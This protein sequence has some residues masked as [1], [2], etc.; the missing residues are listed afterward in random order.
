MVQC[1][2]VRLDSTFHLTAFEIA[3]VAVAAVAVV[4]LFEVQGYR[5][6]LS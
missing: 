4:Y 1:W 3:T 5:I 6:V 2:D